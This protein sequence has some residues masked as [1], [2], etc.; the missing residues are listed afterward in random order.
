MI[1]AFV[2]LAADVAEAVPTPGGLPQWVDVVGVAGVATIL[3]WLFVKIVLIVPNFYVQTMRDMRDQVKAAVDAQAHTTDE[4]VDYLQNTQAL[5]TEA[6]VRSADQMTAL[7]T[8]VN[9]QTEILE[10]HSESADQ[11]FQLVGKHADA[12]DRAFI[13]ISKILAAQRRQSN[14][15][16]AP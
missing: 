1:L 2:T 4:F 6:L 13:D 9:R 11:A 16:S 10:K 15:R 12:A 8:A 5:T 14:R 7:T 3:L